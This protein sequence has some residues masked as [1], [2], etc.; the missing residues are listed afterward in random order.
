[1]RELTNKNDIHLELVKNRFNR[2]RTAARL[3]VSLTYL[4]K[5]IENEMLSVP[6]HAEFKKW[7]AS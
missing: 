7:S 3:G 2:S 6:T 5:Y 4:R 1:M